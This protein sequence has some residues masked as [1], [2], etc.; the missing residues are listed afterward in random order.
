LI[1]KKYYTKLFL[2]LL[3]LLLTQTVSYG[4]S[5]V[6]PGSN[7]ELL[8][9]KAKP[10][11]NKVKLLM[12]ITNS[13][14]S[15]Y[16]NGRNKNKLVI[17]QKLIPEASALSTSLNY[18]N[19][20]NR[21]LLL[22]SRLLYIQNQDSAAASYHQQAIPFYKDANAVD[23]AES[24]YFLSQS[25]KFRTHSK[26]II[27]ADSIYYFNALR[28]FRLINDK[29]KEAAVSR[30]IAVIHIRSGDVPKAIQEL[31]VVNKLQL[32]I[33]D[34]T[35]HKTTDFLAHC[36]AVTGRFDE[37]FK[38]ALQSLKY[39]SEIKDSV[40]LCIYNYRAGRISYNLH[41]MDKGTAYLNQSLLQAEM[42]NDTV[43][44]IHLRMVICQEGM[45]DLG[46][47]EEALRYVLDIKKKYPNASSNDNLLTLDISNVLANCYFHTG[48][49]QLAEE[50]YLQTLLVAEDKLGMPEDKIPIYL[51][52]G[53]FYLQQKKMDKARLYF[54]KHLFLSDQTNSLP[55]LRDA[56]F[57]LFKMD[58][59]EGKL[60]S[61]IR[62]YQLYKVAVDS[63]F[64]ESKSK[65]VAELEI[66]YKTQQK[67]KEFQLL[68]NQNQL[69]QKT[70]TQGKS[71]R[72]AIIAGAAL[73]LVLFFVVLN[74][75]Q[76]KQ[77]ANKLLQ[78]KQ[79]KINQ[80]NQCLEKLVQE[81]KILLKEKDKLLDEKEWLM[82]EIHHRVKNN[83]QIV[84]SL[85]NSQSAFLKD[86]A[87]IL[88][89][90]ESQYRIHAIA[91]I[92]QKLYQSENLSVIDM[93]AYIKDVADYLADN[94]DEM[95]RIS[96][97]VSV[98]H[99][100]L[101]VAQ[102]V[103]LGLIINEAIINSFKYA[104][105]DGSKG[106]IKIRMQQS[107]ADGIVLDIQDDGIGL[108]INFNWQHTQ[109]LG[110]S[111]MQGLAKQLDGQFEIINN[112]GLTIQ[113]KFMP[114]KINLNNNQK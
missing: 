78:V 72:N 109:S 107:I 65:Q 89:I 16:F 95:H 91:L 51:D 96:F 44:S 46:K 38:Y 82:K 50:Y 80:Q 85:L 71:L 48:Q 102:A 27:V 52:I 101:E 104:F 34:S 86:D 92:H 68:T 100:E 108:P 56:H 28:H 55:A 30:A 58:S 76:V 53:K 40:S 23:V 36:F 98:A 61:A 113:V 1:P 63:M 88:A 35:R 69:Q 14:L 9:N 94:L 62:H 24:F 57:Q 22:K 2:I 49:Y 19:G 31:L 111:L 4:Q 25:W 6:K 12:E 18:T 21:C 110:M 32:Q 10:D 90:K 74:R 77:R 75:Y 39:A 84:I 106:E 8:L 47:Y 60:Q 87:A 43:M 11:S 114:V 15:D 13:V 5:S 73:V 20:Y 3:V 66:Q 59:L 37:A 42:Q 26:E 17:I 64:N 103:P 93:A 54:N 70:I 97:T 99:I 67:E 79:E 81:E 7:W 83:L 105:P 112:K 41:E 33:N 45:V 29:I